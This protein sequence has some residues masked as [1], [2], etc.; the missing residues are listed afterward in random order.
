MRDARDVAVFHGPRQPTQLVLLPED[1]L[2]TWREGDRLVLIAHEVWDDA[3][4]W[5]LVCDL[6]DIVDPGGIEVGTRL[7]VPRSTFRSQTD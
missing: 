3:K 2:H 6:N 1:T 5:W 4:P 7:R